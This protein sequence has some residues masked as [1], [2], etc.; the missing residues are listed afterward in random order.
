M[1]ERRI[2]VA[3]TGG[4]IG[5][6]EGERGYRPEPGY[7]ER[8]LR[9]T[10]EFQPPA[11]PEFVVHEFEPL[12]DSADMHPDDWLRIARDIE[13]HYEQ[14]DGFV[15]VHGTDTMAYT[16]A[17]L[18]FML[19]G[20]A[21]PV[22]LT[23]SQ[24]PLCETRNDAR[25]NLIAA[26]EVAASRQLGEVVLVFDDRILRG[27]RARKVDASGLSAFDSPNFPALGTIGS[28]IEFERRLLRPR[29]SEPLRVQ[30]VGQPV[31]GALRLFP[32]FRASVLENMLQPPLQGL[33]L[34][35]FGVGNGPIR[36]REFLAVLRAATER[37]VVIVA[38]TQCLRG[39]VDLSSYATGEALARAGVIGG[40]DM[41]PEAALAKLHYLLNRGLAPA[42]VRRELTRDLRGELTVA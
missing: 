4:T 2:Y 23:G 12:L 34:E 22:V 20:L 25:N 13:R 1:G 16:A 36:N 31:V 35:A 41:T 27:V 10:P 21:K 8:R 38:T 30:P 24:I 9:S 6:R 39:T 5:M 32:G 18:A 19:E 26:F 14:F 11:C 37:G 28:R 42:A 15:V 33:V 3:Y 40:G 17:A 29:G 7:L